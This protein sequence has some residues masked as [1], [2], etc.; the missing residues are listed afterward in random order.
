MSVSKGESNF[1]KKVSYQSLFLFYFVQAPTLIWKRPRLYPET[2]PPERWV[3]A[4]TLCL[5][6][7]R[8]DD[9]SAINLCDPLI[10]YFS[11][12][13][14]LTMTRRRQRP[15]T[16]FLSTRSRTMARWPRSGRW[17]W[18]LERFTRAHRKA[19]RLIRPSRW[20]T[21]I[22]WR[23]PLASW[24]P[25]W[26]SWRESWRSPEILCWRRSWCLCWRRRRSCKAACEGEWEHSLGV[27]SANQHRLS[28]VC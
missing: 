2:A 8:Y 25:R 11:S 1:C 26:L 21:L 18:K 5:P 7:S 6:R 20:R 4:V 9:E 28:C 22:W 23:L 17:T 14:V 10:H 27:L 24:I 3:W 13:T 19:L 12:R 15:W 16:R